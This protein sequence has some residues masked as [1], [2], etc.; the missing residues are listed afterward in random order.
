VILAVGQEKLGMVNEAVIKAMGAFGGGIASSGNVCG[1]LTGGVALISS[2]YS[3]GNLE[4][5]EDPRM[6]RLSYKL[7]KIFENLTEP[8]GSINCMDIARV[9]WSDKEATKDF[10]NNPDSTHKLCIQLVG[11]F[12]FAVGEVLDKDRPNSK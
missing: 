7:L 6:W 3:R 9:N 11:D 2:I 5:K 1:I 12:A 8:F 4:E 10:Y